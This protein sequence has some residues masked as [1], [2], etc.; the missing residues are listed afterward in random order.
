MS[1]VHIFDISKHFCTLEPI[2]Y[3][4]QYLFVL[5]IVQAPMAARSKVRTGIAVSNPTLGMDMCPCFS[6]FVLCCPVFASGRFPAY[7]VLPNGQNSF[8]DFRS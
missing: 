3:L 5:F 8:I 4:A 1:A 2:E 7:G 6:V